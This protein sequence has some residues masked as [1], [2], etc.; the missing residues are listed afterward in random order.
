MRWAEREFS[1]PRGSTNQE[2]LRVWGGGGSWH[3]E[4]SPRHDHHHTPRLR[5]NA[6]CMQSKPQKAGPHYK[7]L[8]IYPTHIIYRYFSFHADTC[9]GQQFDQNSTP[10]TRTN[11][12]NSPTTSLRVQ[13]FKT[14]NRLNVLNNLY[15][16]KKY[17]ILF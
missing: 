9:I 1:Q 10:H 3:K 2:V 11:K 16:H 7:I 13:T 8:Q 6:D 12:L 14:R 4:P 5:P 15:N 17:Y